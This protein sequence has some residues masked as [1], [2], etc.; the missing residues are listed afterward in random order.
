MDHLIESSPS[1]VR[2]QRGY[3][4]AHRRG[5]RVNLLL[6]QNTSST[7]VE[8]VKPRATSSPHGYAVEGAERIRTLYQAFAGR[9]DEFGSRPE[10]RDGDPERSRWEAFP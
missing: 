1:P 7:D 2:E 5:R 9:S 3:G 10:I 6:G 8:T 4:A